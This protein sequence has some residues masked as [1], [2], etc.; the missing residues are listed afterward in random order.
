MRLPTVRIV[1]DGRV[2]RINESDY[3]PEKHELYG[4][5]EA[6]KASARKAPKPEPAVD[7]SGTAA[8]LIAAYNG[9]NPDSPIDPS[10]IEGSGKGGKITKPDVEAYIES[11]G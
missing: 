10:Q 3:D 9:A 5:E 6:A 1:R 11:L 2:V 7:L 4:P 8:T